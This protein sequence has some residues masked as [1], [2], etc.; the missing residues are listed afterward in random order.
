MKRIFTT[1]SQKWPEY[2]IESLVILASILGAYALDNWNEENK[3]EKQLTSLLIALKADLTQDT[4][5][6]TALLPEVTE[7]LALNERIRKRIADKGATIDTLIKIMRDEYDPSWRDQ[8]LYNTNA[9]SS[10]NQTGLLEH[11]PET[12]KK[13]VKNFYNRKNYLINKTAINVND[14]RDRVKSHVDRYTFGSLTIHDQG[15][16]I[17]EIVWSEIDVQHLS[18]SFNS[19]S[20][21]KRI[22]YLS[23]CEELN[24]SLENSRQIINLI[25]Q[26]LR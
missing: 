22:L 24:Y 4:L 7:Q 6:I 9:Y 19:L 16:L 10:L 3:S 5:L 8:L 1:L 21:Y 14:Y 25:D 17:D 26:Q 11:L 15:K 12:L 20:N 2:I 23:L 13:T 18:A